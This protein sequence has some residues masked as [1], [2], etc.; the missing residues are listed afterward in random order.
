[1]V[2]AEHCDVPG[3]IVDAVDDPIRTAACRPEARELAPE[4]MA[5]P[6]GRLEQR[7]DHQLDDG[8]S[9]SLG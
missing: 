3:V 1:M 9:D 5:Q 2:Y 6:V 7:P 4:R 8:C